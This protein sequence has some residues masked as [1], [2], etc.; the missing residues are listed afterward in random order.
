MLKNKHKHFGFKYFLVHSILST[1]NVRVCE[2]RIA[3][4]AAFS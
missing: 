2:D 1:D 3:L 4:C